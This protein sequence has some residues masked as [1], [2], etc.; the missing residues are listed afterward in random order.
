MYGVFEAKP[1]SDLAYHV[2]VLITCCGIFGSKLL[3]LKVDSISTAKP[4]PKINWDGPAS[5]DTEEK[6]EPKVPQPTD[7]TKT[8]CGGLGI[9]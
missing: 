6:T 8:G 7:E 3:W 9:S 4:P 5:D 1:I 2:P